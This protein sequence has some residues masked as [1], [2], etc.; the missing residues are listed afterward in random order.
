MSILASMHGQGMVITTQA[1]NTL[2]FQLNNEM[3]LNII[4]SWSNVLL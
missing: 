1:G 2:L 3:C 4:R